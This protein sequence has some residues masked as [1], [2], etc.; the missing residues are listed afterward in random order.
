M[1]KLKIIEHLEKENWRLTPSPPTPPH[2]T[3][4]PTKKNDKTDISYVQYRISDREIKNY[5]QNI[6]WITYDQ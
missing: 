3:P 5:S 1:R 2:P 4:P 6:I